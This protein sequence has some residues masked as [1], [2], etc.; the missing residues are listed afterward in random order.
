MEEQRREQGIAETQ[1]R[2]VLGT[3]VGFNRWVK[4]A[5]AP[6]EPTSEAKGTAL[7]VQNQAIGFVAAGL[8][9]TAARRVD[10]TARAA[11]SVVHSV[12]STASAVASRV[13]GP[14]YRMAVDATKAMDRRGRAV[15]GLGTDNAAQVARSLARDMT[16]QP[17]VMEVM[18]EVVDQVI[19]AILPG[20]L[21]R[22]AAEPERIRLI[23]QGQSRGMATEVAQAARG[24]AAA[25]DQAI[26]R[27]VDRLLHRNHPPRRAALQRGDV[28]SNGQTP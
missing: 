6:N 7:A 23:V 4:G 9:T 1:T 16:R 21:E 17:A 3:I 22:L 11:G 27:V 10:T 25:G 2:L 8:L 28:L 24:R 20:L 26:D 15:V 12:G 18:Q 14:M 19:D 5:L 13:P